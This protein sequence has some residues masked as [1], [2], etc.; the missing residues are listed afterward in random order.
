[1]FLSFTHLP[2]TSKMNAI[3]FICITLAFSPFV[4]AG[5][6]S[7]VESQLVT[8]DD[9]YVRGKYHPSRSEIYETLSFLVQ[10]GYEKGADVA[11]V[12]KGCLV[13]DLQGGTKYDGSN[14]IYDSNTLTNVFSSSKGVLALAI[15]I[16]VDRGYC[17][18]SDKVSKYWPEFAVNGK[19][20]IT[21]GQVVSHSA[22]LP[23]APQYSMTDSLNWTVVRTIIQ[24]ITPLWVPGSAFGYSPLLVG[25]LVDNILRSVD[26]WGRG[27]ELYAE[28]EI[29]GKLPG[30]EIY[31]RGS[32]EIDDRIAELTN[33][34]SKAALEGY[35]NLFCSAPQ[36]YIY[37]L[38]LVNP[39]EITNPYL[40]NNASYRRM[41]APAGMVYT[42]ARSL[43]RMYGALAHE[44][45]LNGIIR[46]QS[47]REATREIYRGPDALSGEPEVSYT[48][49]GWE[50]PAGQYRYSDHMS[51]FGR[52]GLGGQ[53]AFADPDAKIGFAY[54]TRN[55]IWPATNPNTAAMT[56]AIDD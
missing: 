44:G 20:N 16:A 1:M 53:I 49:A 19:E 36:F 5:R 33:Q 2:N 35:I 17:C 6:C 21:I 39:R 10:S 38:A 29:F 12:D 3:I 4:F 40:W 48:Q 56:N 54:L 14:D 46:P 23:A 22:G 13:V 45:S 34:T 15:A 32:D 51:S 55:F 28:Q 25:P 37:C 30:T 18:Y 27:I 7:H 43:A 24:G 42:N 11:L 41:E 50:R 47:L 9:G 31:Y 52:D 26:P 8:V